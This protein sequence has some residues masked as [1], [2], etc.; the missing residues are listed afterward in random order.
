MITAITFSTSP[1]SA[2]AVHTHSTSNCG[3]FGY[4]GGNHR[5]Y[6]GGG[7]KDENGNGDTDGFHNFAP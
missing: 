6:D 5:G 1:I 3:D 7:D 4:G 2:L